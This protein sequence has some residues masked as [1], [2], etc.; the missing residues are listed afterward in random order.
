M[1]HT[2]GAKGRRRVERNDRH[3]RDRDTQRTV[4]YMGMGGEMDNARRIT[5]AIAI[6]NAQSVSCTETEIH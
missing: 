3:L 6:H 5:C 4:R 2:G 1:T